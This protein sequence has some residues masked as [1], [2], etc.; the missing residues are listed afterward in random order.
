MSPFGVWRLAFTVR[1]AGVSANGR[2]A[3]KWRDRTVQVCIELAAKRLKIIAWG[4]S[5]GYRPSRDRPEGAT[6]TASSRQLANS[7]SRRSLN[8]ERQA[9]NAQRRTPNAKRVT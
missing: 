5:P 9:P 8:A 1:R 6:D 7:L 4:F 2:L 3:M